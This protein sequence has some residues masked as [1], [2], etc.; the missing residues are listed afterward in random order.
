[1]LINCFY[2][3]HIYD[4]LKYQQKT[5]TYLESIHTWGS[6]LSSVS[7]NTLLEVIF[8]QLQSLQL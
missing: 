6:L 2:N 5:I 7:C 1:M 4:L 3:F 8:I